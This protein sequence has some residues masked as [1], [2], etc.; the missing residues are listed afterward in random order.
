MQSPYP[1]LS[2]YMAPCLKDQCR[3]H[4]YLSGHHFMIDSVFCKVRTHHGRVDVNKINYLQQDKGRSVEDGKSLGEFRTEPQASK[5]WRLVRMDKRKRFEMLEL[6]LHQWS[7]EDCCC[8]QRSEEGLRHSIMALGW[9]DP[10]FCLAVCLL[11]FYDLAK[12]KVISGQVATSDSVH[13]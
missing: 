5:G 12:S 6:F 4:Q 9:S 2:V 1:R 11:L 10:L 7:V 3:P 13:S 8:C